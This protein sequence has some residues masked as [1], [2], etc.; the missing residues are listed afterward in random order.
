MKVV[1]LVGCKQRLL[2]GMVVDVDAEE[3]DPLGIDAYK[4]G[5]ALPI[6]GIAPALAEGTASVGPA[7]KAETASTAEPEAL[8]PWTQGKTQREVETPP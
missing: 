6:M 7:G 2:A 3:I 8:A 1:L 5:G 4:Q